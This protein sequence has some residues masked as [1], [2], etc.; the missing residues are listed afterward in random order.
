MIYIDT[1][2]RSIDDRLHSYIDTLSITVIDT[3]ALL[4]HQPYSVRREHVYKQRALLTNVTTLHYDSYLHMRV[5]ALA[6]AS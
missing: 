1:H 6:S 3:R 2:P 5:N 4:T